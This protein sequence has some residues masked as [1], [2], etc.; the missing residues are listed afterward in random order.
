MNQRLSSLR[1][2][3]VRWHRQ[4]LELVDALEAARVQQG[5]AAFRKSCASSS[6][7]KPRPSGRS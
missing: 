2:K 4:L 1:A 5:E 3:L 6:L 7:K